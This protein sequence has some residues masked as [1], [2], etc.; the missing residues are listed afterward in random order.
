[1][2]GA[3]AGIGATET[4]AESDGRTAT[5]DAATESGSETG[6]G[7]ERRV[8]EPCARI[9]QS[10]TLCNTPPE[11]L[12][13]EVNLQAT[14]APTDEHAHVRYYDGAGLAAYEF[15]VAAEQRNG[16]V[17]F[18]S[19]PPEHRCL[20]AGCRGETFNVIVHWGRRC[21]FPGTF[22]YRRFLCND[23]E[24][25]CCDD[26][27]IDSDSEYA[28]Q[29]EAD[30]DSDDEVACRPGGKAQNLT[31][32]AIDRDGADLK[33]SFWNMAGE[34]AD[35]HYVF[36]PLST[37]DHLIAQIKRDTGY[38]N[39]V[40]YGDA[41]TV[42]G[43]RAIATYCGRRTLTVAVAAED[44]AECKTQIRTRKIRWADLCSDDEDVAA[45]EFSAQ[46]EQPFTVAY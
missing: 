25:C 26:T 41:C 15:R 38:P 16:H 17:H 18:A 46:L 9:T 31:T 28:T 23:I 1:M 12:I 8:L 6:S 34:A 21:F 40:V 22:S 43:H 37:V 27:D 35:F 5:D 39:I 42:P 33:V 20:G 10:V 2:V 44:E 19:P 36:D 3:V 30:F 4:D 13:L 7:T 29:T 45:A 32:V 24:C 14:E 11:S